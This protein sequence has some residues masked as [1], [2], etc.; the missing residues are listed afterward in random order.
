MKRERMKVLL[1]Q[2]AL[3]SEPQKSKFHVV[4]WQT[5]SK[6]CAKKRAAREEWLLFFVQPIKALIRG[7]VVA[8]AVFIS[9]I[10]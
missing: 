5:K 2:L 10:S 9:S 3:S 7:V 8:V 1:L 6:N 4:V